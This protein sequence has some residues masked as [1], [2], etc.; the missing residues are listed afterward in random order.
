MNSTG[1][2]PA[3]IRLV[4]W[5][6]NQLRSGFLLETDH[7]HFET[8]ECNLCIGYITLS[9]HLKTIRNIQHLKINLNANGPSDPKIHHGVGKSRY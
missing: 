1:L 4:A 7:V 5:C 6:L 8:S 9:P 2:E 3:T